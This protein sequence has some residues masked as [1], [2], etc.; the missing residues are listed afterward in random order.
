MRKNTEAVFSAWLRQMPLAGTSISTDGM[1]IFSYRTAILSRSGNHRYTFNQKKYS[2]TTS[3]Q[4]SDLL[5]MLGNHQMLNLVSYVNQPE[6]P[7]K[8]ASMFEEG[9]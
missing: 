2:S 9:A 6:V 1:S 3:R 4:Q 8:Q 5:F 7:P